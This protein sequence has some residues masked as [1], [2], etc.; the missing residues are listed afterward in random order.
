[1]T[2]KFGFWFFAVLELLEMF[3]SVSRCIKEQIT[4]MPSYDYI[5]PFSCGYALDE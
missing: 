5:S 3:V 4:F 2:K 1:M